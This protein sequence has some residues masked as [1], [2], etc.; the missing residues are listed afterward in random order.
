MVNYGMS[1]YLW[2]Q[3]PSNQGNCHIRNVAN[4]VSRDIACVMTLHIQKYVSGYIVTPCIYIL[5]WQNDVKCFS[6]FFMNLKN[7]TQFSKFQALSL[8]DFQLYGQVV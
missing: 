3:N 2:A 5:P 4:K 8:D 1:H 6:K 7:H